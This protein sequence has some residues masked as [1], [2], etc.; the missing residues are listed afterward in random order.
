M[1]FIL[2]NGRG[3]EAKVDCCQTYHSKCKVA[4]AL[5]LFLSYTFQKPNQRFG[6]GC[7][8]Y[9]PAKTSRLTFAL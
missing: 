8:N 3:Y 4:K 1:V 5:V 7:R 2:P 9:E 6:G